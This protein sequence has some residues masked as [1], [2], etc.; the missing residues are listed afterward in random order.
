MNRPLFGLIVLVLFAP[1]CVIAQS[2]QSHSPAAMQLGCSACHTCD[3]PT[4]D[5]P[6][7]INCPRVK[8]VKESAPHKLEE[9]PDSVSLGRLSAIYGPARFDH[10][11]HAQ[12]SRM[13]GDCATCHHYSP[14]GRIPPCSECHDGGTNESSLGMPSLKGAFH[15]QCLSCHREWSH[16]TSCNVC[17]LPIEGSTLAAQVDTTDIIG[18]EHPPIVAPDVKVYQTPY[19]PAPTVTFF[20]QDHVDLFG[21]RCVDCHKQENCGSC[22]DAQKPVVMTRTPSEV[23]AVCNDCH[24]EDACGTCHD[25]TERSAFTHASTGWPL[26][27]FHQGLK[28]NA[29]HA[30]GQ[31][32]TR[33]NNDCGSCHGGWA[34]TNFTHA[35]V[36]L[37]LDEIH[38]ELDCTDCHVD[39]QYDASPMCGSCHDDDRNA[40]DTPP[41]TRVSSRSGK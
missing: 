25:V 32:V 21:L 17:H 9:G 6:C 24:S 34:Q 22:H 36:G 10:K 40:F 29:C 23:H 18:I 11:Q 41:G 16:E 4:T 20:H 2:T 28:C 19:N 15:R 35:K 31:R 39:R 33:L 30:A 8:A 3:K 12:M 5:E 7:L 14:E 38:R 37:E 1:V 13:G 26:N 27:R